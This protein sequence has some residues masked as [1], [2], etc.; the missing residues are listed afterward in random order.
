M[1]NIL[2]LSATPKPF[3][4]DHGGKQRLVRLLSSVAKKHKVTLLSLSWQGDSFEKVVDSNIKHVSVAVESNILTDSRKRN[5]GLQNPNHDILIEHYKRYFKAYKRKMNELSY[6]NDIIVVDH[7]ATSPLIRSLENK[8]IPVFYSSQ[9]CEIDYAKQMYDPNSEDIRLIKEIEK[10]ILDR[11]CA[12]SYCSN[13]D[14][15]KLKD[16][17]EIKNDAFYIPNGTKYIPNII[18]GK[19]LESKQILFIGSGHPPNNVAAAEIVKLALQMPDYKFVIA[20]SCARSILDK[21]KTKNVIIKYNVTN[22]EVDELFEQSFAFINPMRSGSGTHLKMMKALSYGLPIISSS[23]GAR[24]YSEKEKEDCMVIA[25]TTSEMKD[26]IKYLYNSKKYIKMSKNSWELSKIYDWDVIGKEFTKIIE[27]FL[28]SSKPKT[29][30][31]NNKKETILVYSIIRN[32]KQYLERYYKQ[33]ALMIKT[34][35]DYDFYL[36]IYEN[37]SND[38]TKKWLHSKDWSIFKGVSIVSENIM[39]TDYGSVKDASR[40]KNLSIA[41][42][43]AIEA[44]GFLEISDYVMMVESDM[45]FSMDTVEKILNFKNV[46]PD[47]DIV[48]GIS[49]RKGNLYDQWATRKK[50][51]Y[52]ITS[53]PLEYNYKK[54]PYDK[55]YSTSNGIC[56][57]RSKP[58]KE[59]VRYGWINTVTK[60]SDCDTVVVCQNFQ[61]K[62]YKNIYIIHDAEIYHEH[63]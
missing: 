51:A 19:N 60:E 25:N 40:V 50:P 56:L 42:N 44:G 30:E 45:E 57:Y 49:I 39:T 41:R 48:S 47:F 63:E 33:L 24:G 15:Y 61:D 7:Y 22:E 20:G 29:K 23:I 2:F 1:A 36:S 38:G 28:P 26:A 37:D 53:F 32:E 3:S 5:T 35:K 55:Y 59:G 18:P 6:I 21:G 16:N 34:F 11:S 31:S 12:F 14:L 58:F 27:S 43:K 62:G 52:D 9:N 10:Y 17:Y 8:N 46:E 54:R 4:E 13:E